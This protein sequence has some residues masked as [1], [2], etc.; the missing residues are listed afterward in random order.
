MLTIEFQ[1]PLSILPSQKKTI[2]VGQKCL[3]SPQFAT[4][5]LSFCIS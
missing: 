5:N 2:L 3:H 1:K 4:C